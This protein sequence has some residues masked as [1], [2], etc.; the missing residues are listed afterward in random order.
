MGKEP[1][2]PWSGKSETIRNRGVPFCGNST[3]EQKGSDIAPGTVL[4]RLARLPL[5]P[6]WTDAHSL[7]RL[8]ATPVGAPP[9]GI[10][11]SAPLPGSILATVPLPL[12]ATQTAPAPVAIAVGLLPT[13]SGIVAVTAP[14]C[15][16][17]RVTLGVLPFNTQIAP[18]P[19][20]TARG[21]GLV[22]PGRLVIGTR[23]RTEPLAGS[24]S[25]ALADEVLIAQTAPAA[26]RDVI[27]SPPKV[28][29]LDHGGVVGVELEQPV[30]PS[31]DPDPTAADVHTAA[32]STR[33]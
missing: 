3:G 16:S 4:P 13:P 10:E 17:M 15:G 25:N 31:R 22:E 24:I 11:R 12:S 20:A 8:T 26:D 28:E 29:P 18:S 21:T 14:S 23:A 30:R 7:P 33:R 1:S 32:A 6:G 27:E 2:P 5:K 19:A 9:R